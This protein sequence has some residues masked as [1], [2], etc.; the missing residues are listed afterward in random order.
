MILFAGPCYD[1]SGYA[2]A[3]RS[4]LKLLDRMGVT[5]RISPYT[6]W[7]GLGTKLP[8]SD[9]DLINKYLLINGKMEETDT[10]LL[11]SMQKTAAGGVPV[12][13]NKAFTAVHTMF[14]TDR[15]PEDWVTNLNMA[16]WVLVPSK[17]G[18]E[19]FKSCG[20]N[21][22]SYMPFWIDTDEFFPYTPKLI[23]DIPQFKFMFFGDLYARKNFRGVLNAYL[24]RFSNNKDV[25]LILKMN[26][27]PRD[28]LREFLIDMKSARKN[29][30][31][32]K[33]YLYNNSIPKQSIPGFINSCDCLLSPSSGEGFGLP[34]LYAMAC[35]KPIIS[36]D[37]SSCSDFIT[38]NNA[39]LVDYTIGPVPYDIVKQDKNF[40]GHEWAIPSTE[41][42]GLLMQWCVN[43]QSELKAIGAKARE[44][45]IEKYSYEPVSSLMSRFLTERGIS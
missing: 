14:E 12:R 34:Q 20:I 26:L 29:M 8:K 1:S 4:V 41:H 38:K 32:P 33:I 24:N 19:T 9:F 3:S 6:N 7:A 30:E 35:E 40:Y 18:V 39:L 10:L 23:T 15:V 42:L 28:K 21:N 5:T 13:F 17:W 25:V 2:V 43:N 16:N 44:I 31:Y 45:V 11:Y 37:W 22:S 27:V 36:T